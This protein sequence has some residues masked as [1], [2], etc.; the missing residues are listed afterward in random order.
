MIG[1]LAQCRASSKLISGAI[2]SPSGVPEASSGPDDLRGVIAP[3]YAPPMARETMQRAGAQHAA[4]LTLGAFALWACRLRATPRARPSLDRYDLRTAAS[5]S[6]PSAGDYVAKAAGT[7]NANAAIGAAEK[8]HM[9]ATDLGKYLFYGPAPDFMARNVLNTV[10]P[11]ASPSDDAD[12][13]ISEEGAA[14][15]IVNET[16][17]RDLA[18]VRGR[19]IGPLPPEPA[20]PPGCSPST[21]VDRL[22]RLPR[23]RGQRRRRPAHGRAHSEVRGTIEGHMHRMA[24]EFLGG[25][26]HCGRP[27]HRFGAPYALLDCA[28]HQPTGCYCVAGERPLRHPPATTGRLAH[29]RRLAAHDQLTHQQSYYKW[30]ER[31]CRGGL[32]V[33]VNL[34]V[35]NRVL[36]ELYPIKHG[37]QLR[38]D[39]RASGARPSACGRCSATSTPRAAGPAR[40]GSGS[41]RAVRGPAGNQRRQARRDH[42]N[43]GLGAL[44]LPIFAPT[45]RPSATR[46]TSTPGST[47]YDLG[48]RQLE[49]INKF[50][51]ALAASRATAHTGTI[52]NSGN[53]RRRAASGTSSPASDPQNHDHSPTAIEHND[54]QVIANGLAPS[55]RGPCASRLRPGAALQPARPPRLGEHAV[56]R[57]MHKKMIFDPD[58]M[59]VIARN[60][61]LDVVEPRHPGSSP[62]TAGAPPTHPRIPAL[63]GVITPYAGG[64]RGLRRQVADKQSRATTSWPQFFGLGYGADRN[65]FG[66]QG[67]PRGAGVPNPVTYPSVADR[68][69]ATIHKQVRASAS[70]TSTSMA[71]PTTAS[72]PTGCRTCG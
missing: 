57:I 67:D 23:G 35:E 45:R 40:A 4:S 65:G 64:F 15:R 11:A 33:F 17:G 14:F 44:R 55:R 47:S 19:Q 29:I 54:D 22:R 37:E 36:C 51:N 32:R 41:S 49:L 25:H 66:A 58:H 1:Q 46:P 21:P 6:A 70:T 27:W 52:T 69:H 10:A 20:A 68:R 7:Y 43:G 2:G 5:P 30:L 50:D 9:R 26:A 71:S 34:L 12:W 72:T 53:S 48:I 56:R 24:F 59:S 61:A 38:R 3:V 18:A 16:S 31:A 39:G 42:G 13:T 62:R 28:D 8:F 60:E 63:G